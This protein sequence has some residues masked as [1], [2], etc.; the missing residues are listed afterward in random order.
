MSAVEVMHIDYG[1]SQSRRQGK[2]LLAGTN[3]SIR[4]I[5]PV[6]RPAWRLLAKSTFQ[7]AFGCL[8][9]SPQL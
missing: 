6:N 9:Q 4:S 3:K 8:Q 1:L 5:S 7:A 2:P